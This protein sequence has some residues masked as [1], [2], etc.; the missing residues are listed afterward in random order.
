MVSICTGSYVLA[1]AGF[2][3]GRPATTHW[4]HAAH[5]QGLFRGSRSTRT[6]CSSTTVT[7]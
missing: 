6:S 1:A 2:L 7:C 3:N 5:F 4:S